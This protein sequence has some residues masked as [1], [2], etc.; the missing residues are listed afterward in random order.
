MS[1]LSR[2]LWIAA[3]AFAA[4]L[5]IRASD[6]GD[7]PAVDTASTP[8][9]QRVAIDPRTGAITAAPA[10]PEAPVAIAPVTAEPLAGVRLSSGAVR[11]DLKGRYRIAVV[12][13]RDASGTLKTSCERVAT[14]AAQRP[15]AVEKGEVSRA[16]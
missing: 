16:R 2:V 13:R 3:V 7:C 4:S 11:V 15:D 9:A 1:S 10:L 8:P 5:P 12:A 6:A 14:P